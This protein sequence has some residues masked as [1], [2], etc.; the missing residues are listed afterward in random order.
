MKGNYN[1]EC[2]RTACKNLRAVFY[3][4]S[5]QKYYCASCAKLIND[6]NRFD[7]MRLYGTPNLCELEENKQDNSHD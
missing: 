6:A 5:T 7:S 1:Q 4:K 3:N 2:N